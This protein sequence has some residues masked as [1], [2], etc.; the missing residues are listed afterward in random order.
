MGEH[1]IAVVSE[2]Q[3]RFFTLD[4]VELPELESGPRLTE[5]GQ[6]WNSERRVP[7]RERYTDSKT[8]RGRAPRGGASHGYDDHRVRRE[9]DADRRFAREVLEDVRDL[10]KRHEARCIVIAASARMLGILRQEMDLLQGKG[11]E[12]KKLA[13]DM[14]NF[15][16]EQI[17]E[18]LAK[19]SVL[20]AR[21]APNRAA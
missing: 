8:G 10:A 11:V 9:E 3:A 20:P 6:L 14:I 21:R 5:R 7:E 15:S 4:P 18:N 19:E 2:G 13:K 1:C 16:P 12:V 17:H